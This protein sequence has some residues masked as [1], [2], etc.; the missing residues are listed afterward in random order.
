[1]NLDQKLDALTAH[2]TL[3]EKLDDKALRCF[4]C[5]HRCLIR[6]GKRGVCQ[7][8]FNVDGELRV[9]WGYVVAL[10]ADPIEKKPLYHF[11]SGENA[12][13]FGMLGCDLHCD[14]C[15]NW[16]TSQAMRDPASERAGQLV[17][18]TSAAQL[19]SLAQQTDSKIIASTYNEPL[20][21]SE[22]AVEI[23]REAQKAGLK[24]AMIS[25]GHATPEALDY[26][27]PHLDGYKIDLKSMQDKNYRQLGGVLQNVL[28]SITLAHKLGLWVEVVTLVVP[29]FN[30]SN[31]ELWEAAR[32]LAGISPNIP[33]HVT[34]YHRD[35]K[36]VENE[37]TSVETLIRAAD[38]GREAG[39]NHVYAG[40]AHGLAGEYESTHCSVCSK[41]LVTRRGFSIQ[42]YKL[43]SE[44][45][46]PHCGTTV[47]GVWT[48]NPKD[49]SLNGLGMPRLI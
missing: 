48:N 49:V 14:Y 44:G 39:L 2:G 9:P 24:T 3:Y 13:S 18:E 7:V 8:R 28:D 41:S 22:W 19:I 38:I 20:I 15:Q 12:L 45:A 35:Y 4:A 33:W 40:N 17:R 37:N 46:C 25:N 11:L 47:A 31:A 21:T 26:L 6:E 29:G 27:A 42:E 30:D 36:M 34:A 10:Q 5:G 32:F 43:T 1:M 16:F 23:F